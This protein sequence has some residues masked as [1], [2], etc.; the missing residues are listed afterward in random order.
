MQIYG[1]MMVVI[2]GCW[3][4]KRKAEKY[5][6]WKKENS[7]EA[8]K[9]Y[10]KSRQNAKRV[11]SLAKQKKQMERVSDLND[12]YHTPH[13]H[14]TALWILFGTTQVN[15]YQKKHS[16][17]HTYRGCQS[18]L[19]CFVHLVHP[20]VQFT[21]LTVFFHNLC[22]SSLWSTSWPGTLHCILHTV[23]RLCC[24]ILV[25]LSTL[26]GTVS[27]FTWMSHIH[28]TILISA[29]WSAISTHPIVSFKNSTLLFRIRTHLG[30]LLCLKFCPHYSHDTDIQNGPC[31]MQAPVQHIAIHLQVSS[32]KLELM[33]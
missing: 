6:N 33:A 12:P 3:S 10:T 30:L 22:P 11:I 15:R 23:Q 13:N 20:P 17:T 2:G 29:R 16:P 27:F 31:A 5:G 7:T 21:H 19:I 32:F 24:L 4:S 28:L 14:V 25:S 9:D 18:Y 8:R 1:N 26:H